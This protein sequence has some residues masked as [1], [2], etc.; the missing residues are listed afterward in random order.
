MLEANKV[1]KSARS[2]KKNLPN[3][4]RKQPDESLKERPW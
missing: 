3:F 1:L 2:S 4:R